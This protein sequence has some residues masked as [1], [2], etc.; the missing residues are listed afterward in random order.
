M[1]NFRLENHPKIKTGLKFPNDSY[2]ENFSEN[3]ST[4]IS[5]NEPKRK[6][7]YNRK[8]YLIYSI[9]A[10]IVIGVLSTTFWT[11][12][13]LFDSAK[14]DYSIVTQ[15]FSTEEIVELLNDD[16]IEALEQR[17]GGAKNESKKQLK[18]Y[19]K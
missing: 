17:L 4:K 11:Q 2:F 6:P 18:N 14:V 9:A 8:M 12:G 10:I 16:D 3:I 19:F 13:T 5:T 15:D 7:V 1:K